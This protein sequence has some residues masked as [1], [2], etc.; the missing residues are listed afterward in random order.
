MSRWDDVI[1]PTSVHPDRGKY[2]T[3]LRHLT[4]LIFH[5]L[6]SEKEADDWSLNQ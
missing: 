3:M 6:I 4:N 5:A 2:D 1:H